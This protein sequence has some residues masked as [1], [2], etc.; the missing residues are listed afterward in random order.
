MKIFLPPETLS[1]IK[2][3]HIFIDTCLLID[4]VN[5]KRKDREELVD[6]LTLF[7]QNGCFFVAI[8]PVAIEF[9]L[10]STEQD[11]KVKKDYLNQLV[12][13]IIPVRV[14]K[15]DVIEESLI[16]YGKYAR[17]NISYTDLCLG[18]AVKQFPNSLV[19]TR[20]YKDF[21]LT[22]FEC[23]AVFTVHL[24][25]EA[26]TYCFYGYK[27]PKEEKDDKKNNLVPF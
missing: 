4:I 25:K 26:R 13:T 24:N 14:I 3:I 5:L 15:Q 2:D 12:T 7:T 17:G 20:N 22:I 11:L 1:V 21:P 6:K 19:L 18:A 8:E 27:K 16:E 23:E 9:F 10:G